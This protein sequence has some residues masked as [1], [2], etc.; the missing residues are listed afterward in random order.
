[1]SLEKL[2]EVIGEEL[3]KQIAPKFEG[4]EWFFAEGKEFV[5]ISKFNEINNANKELKNQIASRDSQLVE[6]QKAAKGNED[7]SKQI[8]EL[9]ATN[10]KAKEEYEAKILQMQK[11]FV[12]ETALQAS[13]ARNSK[14][15]KAMLE[16]EKC[17][18][19]DGNYKGLDEQISQLKKDNEWLFTSSV[20]KTGG[21]P[22]KETN[23]TVD[24]FADFRKI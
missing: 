24:E 9:Q 21:F 15:L 5:P 8:T 14:A 13:G 20:P 18:F 16:L 22:H 6:L 12:L 3:F 1:M 4:K 7:L 11:D 19:K 23:T 10:Q 17:E 2:K